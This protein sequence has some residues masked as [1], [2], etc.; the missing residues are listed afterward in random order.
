[1]Y[2]IQEIDELLGQNLTNED[3]EAVLAELDSILI[4]RQIR[5]YVIARVNFEFFHEGRDTRA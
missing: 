3:E 2:S 1:M 4:V 5:S